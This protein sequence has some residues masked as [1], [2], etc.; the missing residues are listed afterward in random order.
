VRYL[1]D[2]R[3]ALRERRTRLVSEENFGVRRRGQRKTSRNARGA[4]QSGY[5][6]AIKKKIVISCYTLSNAKLTVYLTGTGSDRLT[7]GQPYYRGPPGTLGLRLRERII[8][9]FTSRKRTQHEHNNPSK[10]DTSKPRFDHHKSQHLQSKERKNLTEQHYERW[11]GGDYVETNEK[12]R[13]LKKNK[14]K[15]NR[16]GTNRKAQIHDPGRPEKG[17][18]PWHAKSEKGKGRKT[19]PNW[20]TPTVPE[21][22]LVQD[23]SRKRT[24][25][26]NRNWCGE[27]KK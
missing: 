26:K 20:K 19:K 23:T 14:K 4:L 21:L 12:G 9:V 11:G 1:H 17:R 6:T 18:R 22:K 24:Q 10:T 7:A 15:P 13:P 5:M 27:T 16:G 8:I 25:R 2:G 3:D